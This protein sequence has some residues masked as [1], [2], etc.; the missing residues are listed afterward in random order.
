MTAP[1]KPLRYW[2]AEKRMERD[3]LGM[4][5]GLI[6]RHHIALSVADSEVETR[7]FRLREPNYAALGFA[8]RED[9]EGSN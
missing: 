1:Q 6:P 9:A 8:G 5:L 2:L 7:L 3:V 4:R